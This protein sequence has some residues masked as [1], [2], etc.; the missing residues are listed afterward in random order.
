MPPKF[1]QFIK[2]QFDKTVLPTQGNLFSWQ[3]KRFKA[4]LEK[5]I[6][7]KKHEE[8]KYTS[9]RSMLKDNI[10]MLPD[11]KKDKNIAIENNHFLG[12]NDAWHM[13]FINGYYAGNQSRLADLDAGLNIESLAEIRKEHPEKLAHRLN[14]GM[15]DDAF[16]LLNDAF[17]QDGSIINIADHC[18]LDKAIHLFSYNRN[19]DKLLIQPRHVISLGKSSKVSIVLSAAN[20]YTEKSALNNLLTQIS[21]AENAELHLYLIHSQDNEDFYLD[22]TYIEAASNSRIYTY[23]LT[24]AGKM[25]RNDLRIKLNGPGA[26]AHLFG[27]YALQGHQ[28]VDNRTFVDH[29]MPHCQSNELYK[30]ILNDTSTG[31]FNGKILVEKDAQKTLAFQHN[32]NILLSNEAN[33]NTKPQLEIFADDVKCSHGASSGGIDPN[34]LYYLQARGIGMDDARK[35]LM[36]AFSNEILDKIAL[37]A[38]KQ[39]F[40]AKLSKQ[41]LVS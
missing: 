30:G 31:I 18:H 40:E 9:A 29:A 13:V 36:Y 22:H 14:T 11:N 16:T 20:Y 4:F 2:K 17:L 19:P 35:I 7:G 33:L 25:V 8:W 37:P 12:L 39:W 21:V 6:P 3:Q 41:Y 38:L 15:S 10:L 5:G 24:M 26:E 34:A 23:H 1:E 32:P 27:L 28:H